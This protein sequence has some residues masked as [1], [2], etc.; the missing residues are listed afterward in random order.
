MERM[1]FPLVAL[2]VSLVI[3]MGVVWLPA[4]QEPG[5]VQALAK[6]YDLRAGETDDLARAL[7]GAAN[8]GISQQR[9]EGLVNTALG[10]G[11]ELKVILRAL[12]VI[13]N[14][15]LNGL[16]ASP[17]LSKLGEGLAKK[18]DGRDLIEALENRAL[19]LKKARQ[20]LSILIFEDKPL[21]EWEIVL[22]AVA[23]ALERGVNEGAITD[24][25]RQEGDDAKKMVFLIENLN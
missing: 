25:F 20:L 12:T 13:T 7:R 2:L 1:R 24:I 21:G 11:Q 4:A 18:V 10:S 5:G 14:T 22:V 6:K 8:L 15:A 19:S 16:P 23:G 3:G 9:L 17:L